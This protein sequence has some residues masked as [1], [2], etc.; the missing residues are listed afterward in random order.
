MGKKRKIAILLQMFQNFDQGI[1]RGIVTYARECRNWSIYIEEGQHH[2]LPD[3]KAWD[4]DGFIVN[5]DNRNL[6]RAVSSTRKPIVGIGGGRGWFNPRRGIPYVTTDNETIGL[7]AAEH[8]LSC[9]LQHFAF[10]GY[11]PTRS[12]VWVA[13]RCRAFRKRLAQDGHDC[14]VFNGHYADARQW[15]RI[16]NELTAWLQT[17]PKPVGILACYDWR[18]RHVIEACDTLGL[19]IPDEV[20]LIGVDNDLLL[21]EFTE[22][23]L[24]SIEQG[25]FQIG[26]TA[27]SL[28]DKMID[29]HRP[30]KLMQ[31]I[32]PV[33]LIARQSTNLIAVKDP[34]IAA[35]LQFIREQACCGLQVTTVA[36]RTGWSRATL[37]NRFKK[38]IGRTA[39]MEIRRL[40]LAKAEELLARSDLPLREVAREAGYANEQYLCSVLRKHTRMTPLQ[41]RL[42]HQAPH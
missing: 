22:P 10:C 21:C 24:S 11:P 25:N 9:G 38:A 7:L 39:D 31:R 16:Q 5:F 23:P 17:L 27:A 41:Y 19:H 42:K 12:N 36:E 32:P 37:D 30:K 35:A 13:N 40:K 6:A 8:L 29:G 28:L 14:N 34:K 1:L 33:G 26:Y 4:G 18:A 15:D 3:M 2:W 20:A